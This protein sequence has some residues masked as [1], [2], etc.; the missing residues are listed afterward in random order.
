M[1]LRPHSQPSPALPAFE[2]ASAPRESERQSFELPD[3]LNVAVGEARGSD[4]Q[5]FDPD[6][7]PSGS[8][9]QTFE[10]TWQPFEAASL[11]RGSERQSFEL[12]G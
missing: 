3:H 12:P 2:A 7:E 10:L 11:P 4:A 1:N 5:S 9:R 6:S 8:D